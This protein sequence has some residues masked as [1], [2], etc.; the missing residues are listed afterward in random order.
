MGTARAAQTLRVFMTVYYA[1]VG[2]AIY[3]K[4]VYL[5]IS[6]K[7]SR[8][9][10]NSHTQ[11][12]YLSVSVSYRF[13]PLT[14]IGV[15]LVTVPLAKSLVDLVLAHHGEPD[16]VKGSK[17]VA[18]KWHILHGAALTAALVAPRLLGI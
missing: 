2:A 16:L 1:A 17:F 11:P 15:I 9:H 5:P 8:R 13:L 14:V 18:T 7:F 4:Y 10:S 3:F 6:S 12:I